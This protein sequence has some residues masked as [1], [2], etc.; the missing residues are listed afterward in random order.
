[1]PRFFVEDISGDE[2]VLTGE[3]A[4]HV[5]SSLRMGPGE[6]LVV[7]DGKGTDCLCVI[8]SAFR[9]EVRL[10]V[11]SREPSLG[12]PGVKITVYQGL[13]KGDK[14][15]WIVQKC[16]ELGACRIVPVLTGRSVSQP[17]R[18]SAEKKVLRWRKIAAEAAKQSQRGVVP[19]VSGL[20][21]L[22]EAAEECRAGE[23]SLLFY[24]G[25]GER[26]SALLPDSPPE[27]IRIFIGPEGGFQREE[28][29]ML[30]ENGAR[31][32][33]LG[34]RILRTETAPIAALSV[35]MFALGEI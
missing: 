2:I 9:D 7:C 14:M 25:G 29:G 28:V 3:E 8:E 18:K 6:K 30:T 19:E 13:P 12:E 10:S 1:M 33:T 27:R 35:L 34:P 15:D 23:L 26:I 4:R 22:R 17:D 16:V 11:C 21:S 20:I 31:A 24:E 32:A 5:S